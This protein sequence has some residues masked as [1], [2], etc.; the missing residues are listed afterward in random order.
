MEANVMWWMLS[1]LLGIGIALG[2]L[3]RAGRTRVRSV[4]TRPDKVLPQ[5]L[6]APGS[7]TPEF[8][9]RLTLVQF[10]TTM[11]VRCPST[12]RVL[13]QVSEGRAGVRHLEIDVTERDDLIRRFAL[14]RTPTTLVLDASGRQ[15]IRVSGP[16]SLAQATELLDQQLGE[17]GVWGDRVTE[18]HPAIGASA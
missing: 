4:D 11:C 7:G 1:G 13:G 17:S 3:T 6:A 18:V 16:L 14:L 15:R 10:S 2:W 8:G 5:E 12:A 9:S